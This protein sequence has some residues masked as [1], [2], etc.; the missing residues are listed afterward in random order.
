MLK[1]K[2][3]LVADDNKLNQKILIFI[4]EKN[5]AIVL[6]ANNGRE[7]V[8][9]MTTEKVDAVLMDVQ[10]PEMDGLQA[11]EAIRNE[12]KSTIPVI[13]LTANSMESEKNKCVAAGMNTCVSK[14]FDPTEL[15][16]LIVQ[17]LEK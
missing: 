12:L 17:L 6:L 15:C 3:I 10:M 5:G 16:T 4:L 14:P 7:A 1:G 9:K 2:T 11:T 8:E 13:G